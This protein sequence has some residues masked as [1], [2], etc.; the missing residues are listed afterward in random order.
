MLYIR[1]TGPSQAPTLLLLPGG[2]TGGWFYQP[3]IERLAEFHLLVPDLPEQGRSIDEKPFS[4]ADAAWRMADL[5][6]SRAHGGRAHA[7][8]ISLGAQT[9]VEMLATCPELVETAMVSSA[10]VRGLPGAGLLK[11]YFRLAMPLRAI[12][13]LVRLSMKNSSIPMQ[14]YEDV[15]RE[16]RE[17]TLDSITHVT[18][19]SLQYRLPEGLERARAPVLVVGGQ[20]EYGVIRRSVQDLAKAIPGAQGRLVRNGIHAWNM[21]FPDLFA[22]TLRAWIGGKPLPPELIPIIS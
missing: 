15:L 8:G 6:R 17:M 10:N 9:L 22:E 14:Y 11:P 12:P 21:Q 16:A 20:R 1:E 18:M 4:I 3:Q 5:I 7:V 2:G 19:E 13:F